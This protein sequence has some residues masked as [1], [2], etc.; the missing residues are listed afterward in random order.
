MRH[1]GTR[2]IKS[3]NQETWMKSLASLSN[4]D[5]RR[6]VNLVSSNVKGRDVEYRSK[7]ASNFGVYSP[8]VLPRIHTDSRYSRPWNRAARGSW[9]VQV[10]SR[11]RCKRASGCT[12]A[13]PGT[14]ATDTP[15]RDATDDWFSSRRSVLRPE[16]DSERGKGKMWRANGRR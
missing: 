13:N 10:R 8:I 3:L 15:W 7:T 5:V 11:C 6:N 4:Y 1:R 14:W 9:I 2:S 16:I 12:P